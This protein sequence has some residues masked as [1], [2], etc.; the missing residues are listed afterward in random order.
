MYV[1]RRADRYALRV[2]DSKSPTLVGFHGLNW[3]D[4]DIKY[5]VK[6]KWIPYNPPKSVTLATLAGTTYAQPVP[7]VA[8]FVLDGKTY[9]LEPVLEDPASPQLFFILRAQVQDDLSWSRFPPVLP[10]NGLDKPGE[11]WPD[12]NRSESPMRIHGVCHVSAAAT[13]EPAPHRI[14]GWGKAI[15]RLRVLIVTADI[16]R[17]EGT[18]YR[19][20]A[21]ECGAAPRRGLEFGSELAENKSYLPT[22]TPPEANS[23]GRGNNETSAR[24]KLITLRLALLRVHKTLL[25]MERRP[26]TNAPMGK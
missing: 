23:S 3:Y 2:K 12:L 10:S 9:R 11:L 6:A 25:D 8:E 26:N 13:A 18:M 15:P 4:P 1:I 16:R 14:A 7:G 24:E 21:D 19:A 20:P 22:M 5:R 17:K